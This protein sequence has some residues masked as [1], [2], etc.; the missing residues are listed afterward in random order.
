MAGVMV[1]AVCYMVLFPEAVAAGINMGHVAWLGCVF[2]S[3]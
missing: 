1:L 3:N 2:G